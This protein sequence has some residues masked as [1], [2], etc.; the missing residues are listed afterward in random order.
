MRKLVFLV[1]AVNLC[2]LG[3][4]EKLSLDERACPCLDGW[5][6]CGTTCVPEDQNCP[7]CDL[8][9]APGKQ[10][11]AG[12]CYPCDN[13][14]ACGPDC[15]DCNGQATGWAVASGQGGDGRRGIPRGARR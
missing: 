4:V 5:R 15:I 1:A 11:Y 12:D 10:C 8:L 3:C 13:N 7:G 14:K 2:G 9:C 6:C